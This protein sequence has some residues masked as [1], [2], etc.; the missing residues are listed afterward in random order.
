M[1]TS[2]IL[3]IPDF[4]SVTLD[5]KIEKFLIDFF[6]IRFFLIED[7]SISLKKIFFNFSFLKLYKK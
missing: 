3:K 4:L 1:S 2:F 7:T 6:N 5:F